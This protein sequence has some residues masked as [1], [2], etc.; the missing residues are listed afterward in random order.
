MKKVITILVFLGIAIGLGL[1][2]QTYP[3]YVLLQVGH[4]SI[5]TSLWFALALAIV[6]I[7]LVRLIIKLISSIGSG[8]AS[9]SIWRQH[10]RR[11][12]AQ[13]TLT[14]GVLAYSSENW[15]Q[16]SHHCQRYAKR[17]DQPFLH[18]W[19]WAQALLHQNQNADKAIKLA[20]SSASDKQQPY[21]Y[22]LQ[23]QAYFNQRQWQQC[24]KQ[25]K[26][27]PK[28]LQQTTL[29]LKLHCQCLVQQKLWEDL[30]PVVNQLKQQL[31]DN[32][33]DY[34][35]QCQQ[36]AFCRIVNKHTQRLSQLKQYWQQL[37]ETNQGNSE[38]ALA[39]IKRA[40]QLKPK[41]LTTWITEW[42][43]DHYSES[44][45]KAFIEL[46]N[47]EL[48]NK[49]EQLQKWYEA[50]EKA[51]LSYYLG[52]CY[53]CY[54]QLQQAHQHAQTAWAQGDTKGLVLLLLIYLNQQ[55][56]ESALEALNQH[57]PGDKID[58]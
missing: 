14:Q 46:D 38:C 24:I 26:Q 21:V 48:N 29:A 19:F 34:Y 10:Y 8:F 54:N 5:Q 37:T 25:I 50:Y 51:G 22:L 40:Q 4:W 32:L 27:L 56:S 39:F 1:L 55:D 18:Y 15:Q 52:Y 49:I 3:G 30:W 2:A 33:P 12:S 42:L 43:D 44:V 16:A 36:K 6:F 13:K 31:E 23:A 41:I 57:F 11:L 17:S 7:I 45:V 20:L 47:I 53:Y 28:Q 9:L 35:H 58:N